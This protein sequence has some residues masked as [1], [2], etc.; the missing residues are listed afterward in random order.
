M[1]ALAEDREPLEHALGVSRQLVPLLALHPAADEEV[2]GDGL[3]SEQAPSFGHLADTEGGHP[4]GG[5][6]VDAL[7][8]ETDLTDAGPEQSGQAPQEGGL[9]G[10]VRPDERG[11]PA[12]LQL[13]V[14]PAQGVHPSVAGVQVRD[15]HGAAGGWIDAGHHQP[16]TAL[17]VS[18]SPR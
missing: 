8:V 13:E 11:Q 17:S 14:D 4:A 1:A 7:A 3:A 16:S 5:Q 9:A 10:A 15:R 18:S 12:G 6:A 2:V